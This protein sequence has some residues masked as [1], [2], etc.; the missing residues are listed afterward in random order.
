MSEFDHLSSESLLALKDDAH[1]LQ[2]FVL[3]T[4]RRWVKEGVD[5]AVVELYSE[6]CARVAKTLGKKESIDS[7]RLNE[8]AG[9][10]E[11]SPDILLPAAGLG[12]INRSTLAALS[13]HLLDIAEAMA[14]EVFTPELPGL[15]A[16]SDRSADAARTVGTARFLRG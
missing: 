16:K 7:K 5:P 14:L 13:F 15:S 9:W 12:L 10:I 11:A 8:G 1:A 3:R 4:A 2:E 6:Y